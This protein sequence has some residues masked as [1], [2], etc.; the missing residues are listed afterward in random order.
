MKQRAIKSFIGFILILTCVSLINHCGNSG[1]RGGNGKVNPRGDIDNPVDDDKFN[2]R[3]YRVQSYSYR[4]KTYRFLKKDLLKPQDIESIG[5]Y[6]KVFYDKKSNKISRIEYYENHQISRSTKYIYNKRGRIKRSESYGSN[7]QL[8]IIGRY[9]KNRLV[10]RKKINANKDVLLK[11]K[12]FYKKKGVREIWY[13]PF[14]LKAHEILFSKFNKPARYAY[15]KNGVIRNTVDYH[16][17]TEGKILRRK[18]FYN[19]RRQSVQYILYKYN[20]NETLKYTQTYVHRK[21]KT[22]T[23]FDSQGRPYRINEHH[24]KSVVA[25]SKIK[26]GKDGKEGREQIWFNKNDH[27]ISATRYHP[28]DQIRDEVIYDKTGR[29]KKITRYFYTKGKLKRVDV[30]N[31]NNKLVSRNIYDEK[32]L[33][34]Q[35]EVYKNGDLLSY[36]E[37]RYN[38]SGLPYERRLFTPKKRLLGRWV[39]KYNKKNQ[40]VVENLFQGRQVFKTKAFIYDGDG[41][42]RVEKIFKKK[43]GRIGLVQKKYYDRKARLVK[44]EYGYNEKR[45]KTFVYKYYRKGPFKREKVGPYKNKLARETTLDRTGNVEL[46]LLY[47]YNQKGQKKEVRAYGRGNQY[48][49]LSEFFYDS[50]GCLTRE[51]RYNDHTKLTEIVRFNPCTNTPGQVE[52]VSNPY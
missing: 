24:N 10:S 29:E 42:R 48:L 25:Y 13:N 36:N 14:K 22:T 40:V 23:R 4:K 11:S 1:T 41:N 32:G 52:K 47:F 12:Y 19:Q 34:T 33:M 43:F 6:Y 3:F 49:G 16:Y 30:T 26:Y 9:K 20:D 2:I 51:D 8:D 39:Y 7:R 44:L 46:L 38:K 37:Y 18:V 50:N 21:L 31:G 28:D 5:F 45:T 27:Q 15:Y 35:S 17:S